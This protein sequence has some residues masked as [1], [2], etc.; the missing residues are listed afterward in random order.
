[1]QALAH[2]ADVKAR[3][4][5]KVNESKLKAQE[6]A[7]HAT[8]KVVEVTK[9]VTQPAAKVASKKKL[10][11]PLAVLAGGGGIFLALRMKNR[12]EGPDEA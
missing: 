8:E 5:D 9:P 6:S 7:R 2:K 4:K 10:S 11:I 1:M 3:A 12:H